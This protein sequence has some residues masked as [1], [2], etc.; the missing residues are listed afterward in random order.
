MASQSQMVKAVD[1]RLKMAVNTDQ[2]SDALQWAAT[3]AILTAVE[4]MEEMSEPEPLV[5]PLS[6]EQFKR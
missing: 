6:Q 2:S 5:N 4:V 3:L 1:H